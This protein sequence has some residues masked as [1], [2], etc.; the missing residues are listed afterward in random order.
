VS[1]S[2]VLLFEIRLDKLVVLVVV[3]SMFRDFKTNDKASEM[4]LDDTPLSLLPTN[5]LTL[6]KVETKLGTLARA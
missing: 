3:S 6:F 5:E 4:E 2:V 1:S